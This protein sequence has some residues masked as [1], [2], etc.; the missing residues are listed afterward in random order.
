MG[1]VGLG[2]WAGRTYSWPVFRMTSLMLWVVA[3]AIPWAMSARS[4]TLIA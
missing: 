4:V 1:N 3:K 2:V